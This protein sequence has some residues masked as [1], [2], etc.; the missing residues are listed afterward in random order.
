MFFL[1]RPS[2]RKLFPCGRLAG[3]ACLPFGVVR[4]G[5]LDANVLS[6]FVAVGPQTIGPRI[7]LSGRFATPKQRGLAYIRQMQDKDRIGLDLGVGPKTTRGFTVIGIF[8]FFGAMIAG[9]A[10]TTL[11]W[12]GTPLDRLWVL[13][14]MAYK[15]LAPLG[16]AVGILFLVLGAALTAAGIGWFRRRLWGW[17]LTVVI[18]ATQVLGDVVNY[19]RGDLLH[20]GTGVV[21]AGALLLFLLQPKLRTSF[22]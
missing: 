10:A 17:R 14:P 13:N 19:V 9:L 3:D 7:T 21:I 18:I 11:L 8:L 20:G 5:N 4:R 16:G 2:V 15:Q 22:A 1:E 6:D 12:R